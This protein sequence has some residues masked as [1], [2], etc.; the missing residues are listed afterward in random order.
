MPGDG[1]IT[2]ILLRVV[3][4]FYLLAGLA[5]LRVMA[6]DHLLDQMLAGISMQPTPAREAVRRRLLRAGSFAVGLSGAALMVLSVWAV[7]LFVVAS[8]LQIGWLLWARNNYPPE[9]DNDR[10]G[11]RQTT[12]AAIIYTVM[13][14]AVVWLG[15]QGTF[16]PWFDG[17]AAFILLAAVALGFIGFRHDQWKPRQGSGWDGDPEEPIPLPPLYRLHIAPSWGGYPV[18]DAD[19]GQG[20]IYDD[21]LDTPLAN[22]IFQ[23][24]GVFHAGDDPIAQ[25]YWAQFDTPA[26][27]VAHRAEGAA[28]V[29]AL[30]AIFGKGNVTGPVYPADIRYGPLPFLDDDTDGFAR[31]QE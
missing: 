26:H 13:A 7:P 16:T 30:A 29:E 12:N 3:G 25:N 4:I 31:R 15:L 24:I 21:Y 9:D 11:R 1:E 6:T 28:I 22:R 5:G 27:E 10:R 17:W 20:V 23:W 19:T 2:Q 18:L 8:G 14:A